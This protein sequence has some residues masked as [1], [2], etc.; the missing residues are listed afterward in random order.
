MYTN[1]RLS[2]S[3]SG[4]RAKHIVQSVPKAN[5][6]TTQRLN[7]CGDRH[8]M[9]ST[10]TNVPRLHLRFDVLTKSGF[11]LSSVNSFRGTSFDNVRT[12]GPFNLY[13]DLY[14]S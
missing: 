14:L 4:K 7:S 12:V 5:L 10:S 2:L 13:I 11:K 8:A 3:A 9:Q 1:N 6:C